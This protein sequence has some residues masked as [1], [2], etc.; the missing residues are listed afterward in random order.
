[1]DKQN[2]LRLACARVAGAW[3]SERLRRWMRL[4]ARIA[5]VLVALL[6]LGACSG[7]LWLR[8]AARAALPVLDG[9]VHLA[10]L[11]APVAVRR[12]AHGVPHIEAASE[13]DLFMAQG[14]VAAQDRLWQMDVLRRFANGTLSEVMGPSQLQHDKAQRVMGFAKIAQ[15]VYA[16]LPAADRARFDAYA[17]GVNLFIEQNRDHLPPEFR[18]LG[19]RPQPWS[20]V[21]SASAGLIVVE[22]LDTHWQTKLARERVASKLRNKQLEDDLFPVGS[23]RDRPPTGI[24][25]D[26]NRP[27]APPSRLDYDDEDEDEDEPTETL[28]RPLLDG[29][30][31]RA[32]QR[33]LG[34]PTC[35]GC[36]PG[37]NNWVVSG[38]HTASGKPLLANDMHLELTVPGIWYMADLKA[39]G[40]HAAG[41]TLPGMPYVI[42][43]HNEHVAWGITA[44]MGDVQDLYVEKL[45]GKGRYETSDGSW[46]PLH[47]E[48]EIIRV[49]GGRTVKLD[50]Q[51]TEHGPLLNPVLPK[52]KRPIALKWTLFDATLN[53]MPLYRINTA[54]NW[55][56]FSSALGDWCWP[57]LNMVYADDQGHIAYHAAGRIPLRVDGRTIFD[58]PV[59]HAQA[60][61]RLEWGLA[62]PQ[63]KARLLYIPFADLPASVDPP[64]G[65]LATA[66]ARVTTEKSKYA[67]T[68]EWVAAYRVERIY[69]A[70]EGR[71]GLTPKDMTAV[72]TD[73]YSEADQE[74]GQRIAYAIDRAGGGDPRLQQAALLLR[75]WDGRVTVDAAAAS[76]VN[77]T[78][79]ALRQLIL[80]PK[81]GKE[82]S[83]YHWYESNFALEE[84]VMHAK[85]AWL[86]K[87]CKSWDELL[88]AAVR[89]GMKDGHAPSEVKLWSYGSWQKV[90]L[91][92]PL[93]HLLPLAGRIAG[94]GKQPLS[95]DS[96]TVKHAGGTFGPSQR[97]VMDWSS[98]DASTQ[99]IV[100][101]ESG[102]PYSPYFRDQWKEW[103]GGTTFALPFTAQAVA[104]QTHH[105]LQLRP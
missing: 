67:I 6:L 17:R 57:T 46:K 34:L 49:R 98:V 79:K 31:F 66:N 102:N 83:G 21:D 38:T 28:A 86:P 50:V 12:D 99:N 65:F 59:P 93:A 26:I 71:D 100:L 33:V 74:L 63:G 62:G 73:V 56:E 84:I 25:Y 94:T 5:A 36:Q 53:A 20:G 4:S 39:P 97:F 7:L 23:W 52:E 103:Y 18:L 13:T 48:R 77:Q 14:Y 72:Q 87:N 104:A 58:R 75:T 88:V 42:E 35:D 61:A 81:L 27:L 40:Y 47:V 1:M 44:L 101:G 55:Q 16:N 3:R 32:L 24:P 29:P 2:K 51:S 8:A 105:T 60:S 54:A 82:W 85:S 89:K 11:S 19:Y 91:E 64:S 9:D 41:V 15:R 69:K 95:G 30:E 80:E 92:H 68:S 37:S 22:M 43:G 76:V 96:T 78:R 70:L 10:G 90:D 45:D